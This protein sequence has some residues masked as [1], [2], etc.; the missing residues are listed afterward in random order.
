M[1]SGYLVRS[2]A[3]PAATIT[4]H[5]TAPAGLRL[6]A[7]PGFVFGVHR[8][9]PQ[10]TLLRGTGL[11]RAADGEVWAEVDVAGDRLWAARRWLQRL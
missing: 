1:A 7:G 11:E 9:A 10:G 5:V 3:P 4:L 6:R 8:V 2:D